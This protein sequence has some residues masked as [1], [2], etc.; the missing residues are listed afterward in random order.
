MLRLI[1]AVD[2]RTGGREESE[3]SRRKDTEKLH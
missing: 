1:F 3:H 2:G